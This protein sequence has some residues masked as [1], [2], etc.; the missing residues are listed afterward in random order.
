MSKISIDNLSDSLKELISNAGSNNV[1]EEQIN[2][3]IQSALEDYVTEASLADYST[4]TET[5]NYIQ[6]LNNRI[7]GKASL[8]SIGE[9]L[10]LQ[11]ENKNTIVEAINELCNEINGSKASLLDIADDMSKF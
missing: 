7:N 8:V 3:L 4:K 10:N 6:A 2:E 11:T 9:L 1:N 5:M